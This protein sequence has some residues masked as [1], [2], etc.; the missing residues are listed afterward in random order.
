MTDIDSRAK[1][2]WQARQQ[3]TLCA[4]P[5]P[6][7]SVQQAYELQAACTKASSENVCGYKIGA[8]SDETLGLLG[9][10]EPFHGPLF[11]AFT[12]Y[13]ESGVVIELPLHAAHNPRIEAEFVACLKSDVRRNDKDIQLDEV[14]DHVAWIAPGFEFVGSRYEPPVG[15]PGTSVIGDFGA[16]QFSV[17]GVPNKHW[18]S[19][20]LTCHKVSLSINAESV[21][22]GHS[23]QSIY[24]NP[25]AFVCWLLNHP[26]MV[27]GLKAGQLISCGTCTGAI[28]VKAGD[29]IYADYNDLGSLAVQITKG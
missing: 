25:L 3:G 18:R 17:V 19:L 1:D 13:A 5:K 15:S 23:G 29:I 21:A 6:A 8:T 11:G 27:G 9:L 20:D 16:H 2:L 7:M 24:G 28:A 10:S 26:A 22:D 12:A 14:L 4:F